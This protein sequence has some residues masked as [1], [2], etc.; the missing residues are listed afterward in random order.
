MPIDLCS[1]RHVVFSLCHIEPLLTRELSC[2]SRW[3]AV[4]YKAS[5]EAQHETS[6]QFD[7]RLGEA[8]HALGTQI[9]CGSRKD[10]STLLL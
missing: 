2:R 8:E 1:R 5:L 9:C 4:G 6:S 3:D 10:S 7:R